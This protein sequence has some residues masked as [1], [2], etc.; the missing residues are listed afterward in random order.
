MLLWVF[1][2]GTCLVFSQ[3]MLHVLAACNV[4]DYLVVMISDLCSFCKALSW[5]S[6]WIKASAKCINVNVNYYKDDKSIKKKNMHIKKL[7]IIS[8]LMASIRNNVVSL[9]YEYIV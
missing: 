9:L 3:C 5:K 1:P 6:L 8:V 4:W 2:F 7:C